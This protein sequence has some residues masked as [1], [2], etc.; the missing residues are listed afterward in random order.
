[1]DILHSDSPAKWTELSGTWFALNTVVEVRANAAR[2]LVSDSLLNWVTLINKLIASDSHDYSYTFPFADTRYRSSS[3]A[4]CVCVCAGEPDGPRGGRAQL[5][6]PA[7]R[8]DRVRRG[9]PARQALPRALA[10]CLLLCFHSDNSLVSKCL[11]VGLCLPSE[12]DTKRRLQMALLG[13]S[14][15]VIDHS[16]LKPQLS[17]ICIC[18]MANICTFCMHSTSTK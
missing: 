15:V 3:V 10:H 13:F 4:P 2:V 9:A 18:N 6:G 1:M 7:P 8:A 14:L 11:L 12:P 5:P 16:R 17:V